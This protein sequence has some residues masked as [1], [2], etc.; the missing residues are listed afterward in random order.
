MSYMDTASFGGDSDV[1][2]PDGWKE[3]DD[4]F[5]GMEPEVREADDILNE[6]PN[7]IS[8]LLAD[9]GST[10]DEEAP[11]T[12]EAEDDEGHDADDKETDGDIA[13][14]S[15]TSRILK[16]RF[17]HKDEEVDIGK[18]SDEELI[19]AL[20]KSKAYDEAKAKKIYRETYNNLM[21][22]G[23]PEEV[24]EFFASNKAGGGKFS[25][26]DDEEEATEQDAMHDD[27]QPSQTRDFV[28]E[29]AQLRALYPDFKETPQEVAD[30]VSKGAPLLTAYVAYREKQASKTAA[31][32]QKENSVLKQN[33]A[34]AAKAPV[35]GVTGGGD[36][37]PKAKDPFEAGFDADIW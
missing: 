37:K 34:A 2:L 17:N 3:G 9:E 22:Q 24:S 16:L 19:A 26:E 20:Q 28:A 10:S 30:A 13:A 11:T 7:D 31:A 25:L 12:G 29:V 27:A 8:E 1:I 6:Q 18:M 21:E 15:T 14:D 32:L 23:M 5:A 35:R 4:I 36:T 33:A